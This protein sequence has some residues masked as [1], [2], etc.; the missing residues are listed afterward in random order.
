MRSIR[1]FVASALVA[2][3]VIVGTGASASAAEQTW[4]PGIR[5]VESATNVMSGIRDITKNTEYGYVEN[6][7]LLAAFLTDGG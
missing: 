7:C 4:T 3:V 2:C 1:R 6:V 5:F